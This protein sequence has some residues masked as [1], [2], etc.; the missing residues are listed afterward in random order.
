MAM[1]EDEN[2]STFA[3]ILIRLDVT[4]G[5]ASKY[6]Q[7][8]LDAGLIQREGRGAFSLPF[9]RQFILGENDV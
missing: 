3:D 9:M 4:K 1:C 7:R 5:Y 2:T 8:L 6:R